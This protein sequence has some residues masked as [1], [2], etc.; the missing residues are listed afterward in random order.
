[1]LLFKEASTTQR[2]MKEEGG[3]DHMHRNENQ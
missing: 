1:M 2:L 3:Q